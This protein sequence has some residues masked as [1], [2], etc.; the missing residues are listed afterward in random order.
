MRSDFARHI[1]EIERK[2]G[3]EFKDKSLLAQAFTRTSFCNE[4]SKS[5][6][7]RFSSNEVLEFFG[8]GVLSL[9][10]IT[11][12]MSKNTERYEYGIKTSL[13]EGDFSN[14]CNT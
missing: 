12:L 5:D 2:I 11:V 3:Y 14:I 10:I 7:V 4:Q 1:P 8:D 9:A 13:G 6:K